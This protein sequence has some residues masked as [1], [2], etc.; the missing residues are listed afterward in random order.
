ME[1]LAGTFGRHWRCMKLQTKSADN[2]QNGRKFRVSRWRKRFVQ[3][4]PSEACFSGELRHSFCAGDVSQRCCEKRGIAFF[5]CRLEVSRH[6]FF[7]LKMFRGIPDTSSCLGH[8]LT[9][10]TCAPVPWPF[11]CRALGLT[12]RHRR[13]TTRIGFRVER[14]TPCSRARS[15]PLVLRRLHQPAQQ[16]RRSQATGG[17]FGCLRAHVPFDPSATQTTSRTRLFG[18]FRS[19]PHCITWDTST[20]PAAF[21]QANVRAKRA[22]TAWHAGQQAQ[23][24]AK[25]QRLM[26][27]VPCRWCSA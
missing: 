25:P 13:A 2:S 20:Q 15:R 10:C 8:R 6:V 9:P 18:E 16:C 26:A 5:K 7:G 19:R 23:N 22:P 1:G 14:S 11:G 3:T 21:V 24:G 27:S 17:G 12:C 4:F